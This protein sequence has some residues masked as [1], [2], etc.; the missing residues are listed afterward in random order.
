MSMSFRT[1]VVVLVSL[2]TWD[3]ASTHAS[4]AAGAGEAPVQNQ[5]TPRNAAFQFTTLAREGRW[6]EAAGLLQWP[7]GDQ[8][9]EAT[10]AQVARAL[11][12]MIE[13][14]FRID[15]SAIPGDEANAAAEPVSLGTLVEGNDELDVELIRD[16][17]DDWV[18]SVKT[19]KGIPV[20]AREMGVWWITYLPQFLVNTTVFELELWQWI[21]LLLVAALVMALGWGAS[22]LMH[23]GARVAGRQGLGIVRESIGVLAAPVGVM[24]ALLAMRMSSTELALSL[25]AKANLA[26]GSRAVMVL[27]VAWGVARWLRILT[28]SIE[29]TLAQ[30]GIHDAGAIVRVGRGVATVLVY[31]LS[32][33]IA[34]QAM[35]LD[36]GAVV[37]GLGIGT[38]AIALAS[39]QT[40]ANLF[41]GA[42]VIADKVLKPGDTCSIG[43]TVGTVE[44]IGLR[45]TTLRTADR[46]VL[47]VA[48]G[49]LAQ[50]RVE[51]LSERDGFRYSAV[52]GLRYETSA[53]SMRAILEGL[54][55]RLAADASVDPSS[56]RVNFLAFGSSSLDVDVKALVRTTDAAVYRSTVERLNLDIMEIVQGNGSGFAFPSQ[57][58][59]LA[60][61]GAPQVR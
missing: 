58:V 17:A 51:K 53:A 24:L 31:L 38:A 28:L 16:D 39:Q 37:A 60:R 61:D 59:Y 7:D 5:D 23:H 22:K 14:N 20:M 47:V 13:D 30:R 56:V 27:A 15:F 44:R 45:S 50:A 4:D 1:A 25:P 40:L 42:S 35:G 36:L 21:A 3:V 9:G 34:L 49:D 55:A 57:T 41:G 46:T 2:L 12:L 26:T 48:N 10:P 32:L 52:L 11:K 29:R 33:S 6:D 19:V 43:G 54:R 8:M 18:I